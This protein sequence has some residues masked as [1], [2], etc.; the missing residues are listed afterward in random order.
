NSTAAEAERA[1]PKVPGSIKFLGPSMPLPDLGPGVSSLVMQELPK[2]RPSTVFRRGDFR[3]PGEPMRPATPAVLP[4]APAGPPSRLPRLT[5]GLLRRDPEN[6]LL[7]RGPR[8][9]LD[10]E[11]IRDNALAVAGLL[12]PKQFGPPLRPYQ[13]P[14]LWTKIGGDKVDYVVSPGPERFRRG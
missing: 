13:P 10:A 9:R 6:R 2:P 14:G 4:P 7:A 12:S 5:P 3:S 11:T 8:F 1:N